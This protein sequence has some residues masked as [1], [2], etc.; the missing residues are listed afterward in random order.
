MRETHFSRHVRW[1][2][3]GL[4]IIIA[5]PACM[6]GR[7]GLWSAKGL[8]LDEKT[9]K[10]IHKA[11]LTFHKVE[12]L[13]TEVDSEYSDHDYHTSNSG[14]FRAWFKASNYVDEV[15]VTVEHPKYKTKKL[16]IKRK[17]EIT[18]RLTPKK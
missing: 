1:Y 5:F 3:V 10:P 9:G 11:K 8:V 14:A 17:Q 4:L 2:A 18:I 16:Q 12:V 7:N 13:A 15:E 6:C